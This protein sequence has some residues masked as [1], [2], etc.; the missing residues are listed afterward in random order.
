MVYRLSILDWNSCRKISIEFPTVKYNIEKYQNRQT[1]KMVI[2]ALRYIRAEIT[3][4]VLS[5]YR[6]IT[7]SLM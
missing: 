5:T 2:Y 4:Y 1:A 3:M 7:Y 6:I